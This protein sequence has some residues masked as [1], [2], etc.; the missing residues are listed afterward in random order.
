MLVLQLIG[1]E[2]VRVG[3]ESVGGIDVCV[4]TSLSFMG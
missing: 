3:A 4:S 1:R 2:E